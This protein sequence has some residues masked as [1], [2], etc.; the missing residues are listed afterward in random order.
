[1]ISGSVTLNGI[2]DKQL[3]TVLEAKIHHEND[4][5]FDPRHVQQTAMPA[6]NQTKT[7]N[8][9]VIVTWRTDVGFK[10]VIELQARLAEHRI[11]P[12]E[13]AA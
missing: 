8:N 13:V 9:N 6:P 1:M 12:I 7:V 11:V 5:F 10:A 2:T 3:V 4:V